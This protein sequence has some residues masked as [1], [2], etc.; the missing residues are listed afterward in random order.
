M[1]GFTM[2]I[3]LAPLLIGVILSQALRLNL[4]GFIGVYLMLVAGN[5]ALSYLQLKTGLIAPLVI[6]AI[7][8]VVMVVMTGLFGTKIRIS[9]YALTGIGIGLFPWSLGVLQSVTYAV[10]FAIFATLIALKPKIKSPFKR[11]SL[12]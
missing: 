1:Q 7:G 11:G 4:R 9:D 12:K 10:I 2:A 6:G 5:V 3:V 8:L